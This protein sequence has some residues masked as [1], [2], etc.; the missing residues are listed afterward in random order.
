MSKKLASVMLLGAVL[1]V[2]AC[3][4][5]NGVPAAGNEAPAVSKKDPVELSVFFPFPADW[6]EEDFMKTFGQ[7][8]M[9]KFPHV[10][11]KYIAGGKVSELLT[12]GQTIDIMFA[13]I[14]ATPPHLMENKLEYDITPQIKKY[15]YNLNHLEP[16]MVDT[17]RQ[18]AGGTGIYGL[19]VYVPPSTIYYNKDIFDKFGV[20]YPKGGITW[21]EM[22]ELTKSLTRSDGGVNFTGFASSYGHLAFMNQ[23]S[24][25]LVKTETKKAAL[26]TDEKWKS[27]VD[28]LVR[29]YKLPGYAHIKN[30]QISEP[31][32]RNRFFKDRTAAMFLAM[33]A[34]HNA[35]E[36][37]DLNWDLAPFPVLKDK[38]DLGPQAYPTYFYVTSMSK[39]K[40]Q[41]FEIIAYLTTEE[42][43][44]QQ[45]KEGK[46]LTS[47][48][49]KALRQTFGQNNPMYA[50]KNIK[51][52][53]PDKYAP[54]GSVNKYNGSYQ[55][56]FNTVL[57]DVIFNNKDANTALREAAERINKKIEETE[58]AAAA[59]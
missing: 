35:K 59:K 49:N 53:Q 28:N 36:I 34:L 10:T 39:H 7:P 22:F 25:P 44:S 51:A 38:P 33:T 8:I 19:P 23:L 56:E 17:G 37:G 9:K 14:G 40:D 48:N 11:I 50:G 32:E 45:L 16:T 30:N 29:F 1:A 52:F 3:G 47:L 54:A 21:D 26:D 41:A 55:G 24:A 6:P 46:F 12:A 43:Q 20:P 2:T 27:F 4:K 58:A 57:R 31:N 18:L 13:S 15:S 42:Y 5:T